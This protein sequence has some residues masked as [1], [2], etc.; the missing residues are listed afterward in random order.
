MDLHQKRISKCLRSSLIAGHMAFK[1]FF[2]CSFIIIFFIHPLSLSSCICNF[3]QFKEEN[4][5]KMQNSTFFS[6]DLDCEFLTRK[7]TFSLFFRL[8]ENIKNIKF[9]HTWRKKVE[10]GIFRLLSLL[11]LIGE[12]ILKDVRLNI[13]GIQFS[14]WIIFITNRTLCASRSVHRVWN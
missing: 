8:F 5:L 3:H 12:R 10:F 13:A 14:K 2:N 9:S 1:V 4:C 7:E 11:V 6:R